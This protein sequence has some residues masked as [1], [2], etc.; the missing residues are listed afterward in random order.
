MIIILPTF[1]VIKPNFTRNLDE[2][3]F[4]AT[5]EENSIKQK[6]ANYSIDGKSQ[7]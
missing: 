2:E 6:L 7:T 4:A 3:Y 5:F 1:Q